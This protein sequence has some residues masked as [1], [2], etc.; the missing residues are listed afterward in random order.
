MNAKFSVPVLYLLAAIHVLA[1]SEEPVPVTAELISE[2]AQVQSGT[3][4]YVGVQFQILPHW[5]LYWKNPGDSG[6]PPNIEWDLPEGFTAGDIEWPYPRYIGMAGL[7]SFSYENSLLLMLP[8]QAP[9]SLDGK[10]EVTL[11]AKVDWLVCEKV[12]LPGNAEVSLTLP[13]SRKTPTPSPH[14]DLFAKVRNL[15]PVPLPSSGGPEPS[16]ASDAAEGVTASRSEALVRLSIPVGLLGPGD[17]FLRFFPHDAMT[18]QNTG[19]QVLQQQQEHYILT[20]PLNPSE[21]EPPK[22]VAGVLVSE[23]GWAGHPDRNALDLQI[24]FTSAPSAA[25]TAPEPPSALALVLFW[26]FVGGLILNLMP[27]VFPVLGLKILGFVEHAGSSRAKVTAHGIWFTVGVLVSFWIL[28]GILIAIRA[29]G[30]E[31]GWG[32]QLQSPLFVYALTILLFAFALNLS[33]VFEV[34]TTLTQL[35]GTAEKYEGYRGTFMSGVLAT[36]VATP[37]AAPILAGALGTALTLPPAQSM[38]VFTFIALGLSGPY[39]LFSMFPALI[40]RLPRPGPWMETFK[41]AMAFLLYA[42]VAYLVWV[43][44][45]QVEADKSLSLLFG[46]V[47]ISV[48]AWVYGRFSTLSSSARS[49]WTGRAVAALL[50][51]GTIQLGLSAVKKSEIIWQTWSPEKVEALQAEG[52]TVYVDFTARWCLTCKANKLA[53]FT[54]DK[55]IQTFTRN[56]IAALKADWTNQDPEITRALAAFNRSAVPFNLVY[57]P[58]RAH[59]VILPELLTPAI[60]LEALETID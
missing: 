46:L 29:A 35:G 40:Q 16:S 26:A 37:C 43:L 58:G 54:S 8:I 57:K 56:K 45:G 6:L 4:F 48:A 59:P 14:A 42:T 9:A 19:H 13:V 21:T 20:L 52:R 38:L 34:G 47:L 30:H 44:Q 36:L 28:A 11:S 33:G 17:V 15:H 27:C 5:H 49:R 10:T 55:V 53:V 1:A 31:L 22:T 7:A 41:Q 24:E 39:L 2:T 23:T 12:C 51:L 50:L 3:S 32:F 25:E 18:Y 60:V